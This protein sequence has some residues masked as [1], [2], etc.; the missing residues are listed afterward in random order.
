MS[1]L[2]ADNVKAE[3]NGGICSNCIGVDT[4]AYRK[5]GNAPVVYCEEFQYPAGAV[6]V[7]HQP[8]K[9]YSKYVVEMIDTGLGLCCNCGSR[10]ECVSNRNPK[11]VLYCEE[12]N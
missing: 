8:I 9:D 6:S 10:S 7:S 5:A 1:S 11:N 3:M 4:C 12:Y 2:H